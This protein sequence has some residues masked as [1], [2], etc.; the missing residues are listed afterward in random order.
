[1]AS[2]IIFLHLTQ[3]KFTQNIQCIMYYT[4]FFFFLQHWG[5]N[6]GI[7]LAIQEFLLLEPLSQPLRYYI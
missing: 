6:S 1:M 4:F 5:L 2:L 3:S 7:M